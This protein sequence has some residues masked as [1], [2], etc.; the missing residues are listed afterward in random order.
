MYENSVLF[1]FVFI[2]ASARSFCDA[3]NVGYNILMSTW[4][5]ASVRFI[6]CSLTFQIYG[7]AFFMLILGLVLVPR[8]VSVINICFVRLTSF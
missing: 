3:M 5:F 1:A 8:V 6:I 4:P 2:P 7:G